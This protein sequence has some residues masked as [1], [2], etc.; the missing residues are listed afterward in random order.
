[1]DIRIK[2]QLEFALEI[3]KVKNVFRQT[4]LSKNGRNE[5][6]QAIADAISYVIKKGNIKE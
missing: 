4:H 5:K 6:L 1:M 3:D 2:K